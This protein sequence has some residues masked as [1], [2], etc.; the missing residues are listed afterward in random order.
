VIKG[1]KKKVTPYDT[2]AIQFQVPGDY[3][4]GDQIVVLVNPATWKAQAA[5]LPK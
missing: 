2:L 3:K 1:T 5:L 4:E